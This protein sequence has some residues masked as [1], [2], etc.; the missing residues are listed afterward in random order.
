MPQSTLYKYGA[1]TASAVD[2]TDDDSRDV[3]D[4]D[5]KTVQNAVDVSDRNGRVLG[6]VDVA[7]TVGTSPQVP[8]VTDLYTA[9]GDFDTSTY[10]LTINPTENIKELLISIIGAELNVTFTTTTGVVVTVP[11]DSPTTITQYEC[12]QIEITDPGGTGARIAGSWAGE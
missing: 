12:D 10:P 11:V 8:T 6:Q 9:G 3:G 5:V 4:V 1:G 7:N 2:V